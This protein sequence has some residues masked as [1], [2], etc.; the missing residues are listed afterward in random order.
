MKIKMSLNK[1][2]SDKNIF[3]SLQV[4]VQLKRVTEWSLS[5][6]IHIF[7]NSP[8]VQILQ[9]LNLLHLLH[10]LW[11]LTVNRR[12]CIGF[13]TLWARTNQ[14]EAFWAVWDL[15]VWLNGCISIGFNSSLTLWQ[16]SKQ[17]INTAHYNMNMRIYPQEKPFLILLSLPQLLL[18]IIIISIYTAVISKQQ[19]Y[20]ALNRN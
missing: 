15:W 12:K 9:T 13:P 20:K 1:E 4:F 10:I 5:G 16:S 8:P 11:S 3:C 14:N 18:I 2:L 7:T 6:L 19:S 17:T